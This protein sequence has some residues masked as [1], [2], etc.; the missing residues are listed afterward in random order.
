MRSYPVGLSRGQNV[1]L[2]LHLRH[3]FVCASSKD[4]I[5]IAQIHKLVW[6]FADFLSDKFSQI[7]CAGL[8]YVSTKY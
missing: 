4:S 1:R 5:K 2:S 7:S 8:H 3:Y 6:V